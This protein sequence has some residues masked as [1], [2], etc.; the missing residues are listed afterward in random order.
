LKMPF[1]FPSLLS[2]I[3]FFSAGVALAIITVTLAALFPA[4]RMS[5]QELAVA[6]RE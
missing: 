2:F 5:R 3:G 4:I 6:M 1:L